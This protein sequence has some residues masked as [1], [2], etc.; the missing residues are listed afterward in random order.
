MSRKAFTTTID[1]ELQVEFKEACKEKGDKMNNVIEAL[2]R[3][4][5]DN[6]LEV[7]RKTTYFLK[8]K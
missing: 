6:D 2:M 1:E 3:A 8:R 5:I 4:Y 7:E